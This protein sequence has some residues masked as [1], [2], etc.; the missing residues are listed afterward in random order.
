[1]K[2]L[3]TLLFSLLVLPCVVF[4]GPASAAGAGVLVVYFSVPETDKP[5]KM[6]REEELSTVVIDG[7][8]LGNTQY[9]AQVISG[10]TG[11][12]LFRIEPVTPY[13]VNHRELVELARE[14]QR[15][16]VRP[17]IAGTVENMD[18]YHTVFIGYP[19]WYADMPM[20]MYTFLE[21]YDL[22]GKTVVPFV[23]HG[24]SGF[25]RTIRTIAEKQP[26]ATVVRNGLSIYR[27]EVEDSEATI[28]EWLAGLGM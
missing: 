11:G 3:F 13:T 17:A 27:T 23:T 25:S 26:K 15:N 7:K 20:I 28:L 24:G 8:V 1:M 6:T 14:E 21:Q 2:R 16:A 10:R 4:A 18:A 5:G 19:N 12:D 22:S 9:V